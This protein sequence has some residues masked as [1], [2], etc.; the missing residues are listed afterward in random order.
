MTLDENL[1]DLDAHVRDFAAGEGFAYAVL[2]P[3]TED[4][5]GCVYVYPDADGQVDASVRSW[6]RSSRSELDVPLWRAVSDWL[7]SD[8]WPFARVAYAARATG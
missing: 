8:A 5:I 6:V 2:D 7:A 4:V 1:A 3:A